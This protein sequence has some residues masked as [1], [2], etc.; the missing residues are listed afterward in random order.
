M[1][2][3]FMTGELCTHRF[4][5][6]AVLHKTR[7]FLLLQWEDTSTDSQFALFFRVDN[8]KAD[9]FCWSFFPGGIVY[10]NKTTSKNTVRNSKTSCH[11]R[12]YH[13]ARL[14][15]HV[16]EERLTIP[17]SV[18]LYCEIYTYIYCCSLLE[19]LKLTFRLQQT[20]QAL[21]VKWELLMSAQFGKLRILVWKKQERHYH[22]KKL[23][24]MPTC[25]IQ[26]PILIILLPFK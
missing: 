20:D 23:F 16:R 3:R 12:S 19:T 24:G 15:K 1:S 8:R 10:P 6:N 14:H 18:F 9:L 21:H 25:Y 4:Y 11:L 13:R 22:G 17:R 26:Q 2:S 5:T 7:S